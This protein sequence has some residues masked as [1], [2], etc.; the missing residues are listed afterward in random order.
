[1]PPM[2]RSSEHMAFGL[3]APRGFDQ[4]GALAFFGRLKQRVEE[5]QAGLPAPTEEAQYVLRVIGDILK[6][7][8]GR[9]YEML[10]ANPYQVVKPMGIERPAL[11]EMQEENLVMAA[12]AP[13]GISVT[14]PNNTYFLFGREMQL[15]EST[16][17][18]A[19]REFYSH[20]ASGKDKRFSLLSHSIK[21]D[22]FEKNI[23]EQVF[24]LKPRQ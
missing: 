14:T 19:G 20:F 17:R 21:K 12:F 1:M 7:L 6:D 11:L 9:S 3:P 23:T 8:T 24:S 2:G 22:I 16:L 15:D 4:S 10:L 18:G 13:G 5:R